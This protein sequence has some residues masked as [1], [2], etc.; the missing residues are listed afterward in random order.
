MPI[1]E[2]CGEE[3]EDGKEV[4]LSGGRDYPGVGGGIVPP[5]YGFMCDECSELDKEKLS[6]M[7][8]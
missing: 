7:L 2:F 3:K 4:M 1:C 6:E 5:E 8:N